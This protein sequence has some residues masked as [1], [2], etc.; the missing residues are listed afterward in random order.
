MSSYKRSINQAT[1]S[2]FRRIEPIFL[3]LI[4]VINMLSYSFVHAEGFQF[5]LATYGH[6]LTL[7]LALIA[8]VIF[9]KVQT[10][11]LMVILLLAALNI[12]QIS[13][14]YDISFSYYMGRPEPW[15]SLLIKPI[16]L[17]LLILLLVKRRGRFSALLQAAIGTDASSRDQSSSRKV[18]AYRAKFESL[19]EEQLRVKLQQDLQSEARKSIEELLAE[20]QK[21]S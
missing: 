1:M 15:L 16:W 17:A 2:R 10:E 4:L 7:L 5:Y 20:R 6:G 11:I 3:G 14:Y 12:L 8:A 19:S 18:D 21:N 13:P 9:P